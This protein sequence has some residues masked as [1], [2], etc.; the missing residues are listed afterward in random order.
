MFYYLDSSRRPQ[1]PHSREELEEML[2]QGVLTGETC[3]AAKGDEAW[4]PL[5]KLL[6]P[7]SDTP[8]MQGEI[9]MMEAYRR[10]FVGYA[11]T[12]GRATRKEY[13]L[14]MTVFG[15]SWLILTLV[16]VAVL[17]SYAVSATASLKFLADFDEN[18]IMSARLVLLVLA[19]VTG[20]LV[21][22]M[23]PGIITL[24]IRR[25]HDLGMRGWWAF[26]PLCRGVA[27]FVVVSMET[28]WFFLAAGPA[29]G[30]AAVLSALDRP[31]RLFFAVSLAAILILSMVDSQRGSNKYGPSS[32]YPET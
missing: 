6:H 8:S 11:T 24:Q 23:A 19:V 14:F 22:L 21:L 5:E 7:E 25:L 3:V 26:V 30:Q 17:M 20:G 28:L 4:A 10:A 9:S 29:E 13:W 12:S 15:T 1:G 18:I 27:T 2:K 31:L 16:F 32:K